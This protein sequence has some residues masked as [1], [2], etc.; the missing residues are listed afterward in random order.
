LVLPASFQLSQFSQ[1]VSGLIK[2]GKTT[3]QTFGKLLKGDSSMT[4]GPKSSAQTY[5]I[6][7]IRHIR[8][9]AKKR[10]VIHGDARN[11]MAGIIKA[12]TVR[13]QKVLTSPA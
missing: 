2:V 1:A 5:P 10:V 11:A 3:H 4:I 8:Q 7:R 13:M 9:Q 6:K 12:K